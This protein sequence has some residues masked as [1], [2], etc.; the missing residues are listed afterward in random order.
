MIF[1]FINNDRFNYITIFK[2]NSKIFSV[3]RSAATICE[4]ELA[5]VPVDPGVSVMPM[6]GLFKSN[7][8]C[9]TGWMKNCS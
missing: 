9:P 1:L 3:E 4:R 7:L 6:E 5:G 8:A 2:S